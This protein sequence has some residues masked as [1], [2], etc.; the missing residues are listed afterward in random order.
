MALHYNLAKVY[1]IS[2]NDNDF[3]L[4]I[5]N[6]FLQEVPHELEIIKEGIKTKDFQKA[7]ASSHKIKPTF[8]LL[9]MDLAFD[10]VVQ[11]MDWASNEGQ[12][13]DIREI[14]K[15]LKERVELTS[16]EIRKNHNL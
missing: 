13:K 10:E 1:E 7:Q 9:G 16:K 8:D 2:A 6:L 5:L 12:K 11:I 14:F 3:A 4:Q 15:S